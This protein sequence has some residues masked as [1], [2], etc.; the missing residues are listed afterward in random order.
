MYLKEIFLRSA[1][2]WDK[3]YL[4]CD[5]LQKYLGKSFSIQGSS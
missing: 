3:K 2:M 1:V 5:I 4:N